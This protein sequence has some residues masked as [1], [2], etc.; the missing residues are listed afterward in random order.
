MQNS[1]FVLVFKYCILLILRYTYTKNVNEYSY[2]ADITDLAAPM[3][4][5]SHACL[6]ATQFVVNKGA[7]QTHIETY[8]D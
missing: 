8:F 1:F 7:D 4:M 5:T 3:K 2:N 6:L